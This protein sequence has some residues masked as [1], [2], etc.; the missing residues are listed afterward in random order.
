MSAVDLDYRSPRRS[1]RRRKSRFTRAVERVVYNLSESKLIWSGMQSGT[2][3]NNATTTITLFPTIAQGTEENQRVGA[4]VFAMKASL[5]FNF[6][7]DN[8]SA[9]GTFPYCWYRFVIWRPR[10]RFTTN[11]DLDV[12]GD[13]LAV[14]LAISLATAL[15]CPVDLRVF[16]VLF[17]KSFVVPNRLVGTESV[18]VV[19]NPHFM[20]FDIPYWRK[21][22]Y[23]DDVLQGSDAFLLDWPWYMTVLQDNANASAFVYNFL[24]SYKD[25]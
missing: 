3:V 5:R 4:E 14:P 24:L 17:D 11:M 9:I 25:V 20:Q 8:S 1:K 22:V 23:S 6:E 16:E 19:T 18:V 21:M 7:P 13:P 2:I 15:N 12:T 10:E